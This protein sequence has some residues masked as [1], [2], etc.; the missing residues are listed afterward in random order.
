MNL[1]EI[2]VNT[3]NRVDSACE[4]GIG[5]SDF[6][7]H[8]ML[9]DVTKEVQSTFPSTKTSGNSNQEIGRLGIEPLHP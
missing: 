7:S 5:P 6:I 1:K 9:G 8:G 4:C 3:R 2:V